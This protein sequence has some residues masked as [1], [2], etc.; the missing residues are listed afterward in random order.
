[1]FGMGWFEILV[2]LVLALVVL[3]PEKLPGIARTAGKMMRQ[4]RR[5]TSDL[6]QAIDLEGMRGDLALERPRG[7]DP[8]AGLADE[9]SSWSAR[10]KDS[11]LKAS[12][13]GHDPD[14][15]SFEGSFPVHRHHGDLYTPPASLEAARRSPA[16]AGYGVQGQRRAIT[17]AIEAV[18]I[19][20]L[21]LD[22]HA[23]HVAAVNT[24]ALHLLGGVR[25]VPVQGGIAARLAELEAE[26]RRA[27][28]PKIKAVAMAPVEASG[29]EGAQIRR[30]AIVAPPL[31]LLGGV[32][33]VALKIPEGL[34]A[35]H[36][37][38]EGSIEG[39]TEEEPVE[40]SPLEGA[41]LESPVEAAAGGPLPE[42]D[43][44]PFVDAGFEEPEVAVHA[45]VVEERAR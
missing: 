43:G 3:G 38:I 28:T 26:R 9:E 8:Y 11:D 13:D 2:I 14:E 6:R 44:D 4:L 23:V 39:P 27:A 18:P 31:A 42:V 29:V 41:P 16:A 22:P 45:A 7:R 17:G 40:A 12:M 5:A 33:A 10:S 37:A 19:A 34:L 35:T 24:P 32:K 1:M 30:A 15:D 25:E 20:D 21:A 36:A